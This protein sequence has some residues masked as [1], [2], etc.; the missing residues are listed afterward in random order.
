M[1]S[2]NKNALICLASCM[3]FASA[4]VCHA[5]TSTNDLTGLKSLKEGY[6]KACSKIESDN[7]SARQSQAVTYINELQ[8]VQ[9][10][11]QKAG[12]LEGLTAAKSE[13]ERF[14]GEQTVPETPDSSLPVAI[15]QLQTAYKK[16]LA[17][18]DLDKS[19]KI[20]SAVKQYVDRLTALQKNLTKAGKV[21]EALEVNAEIKSV[22]AD[23]KVTSA[24]FAVAAAESEKQSQDVSKGTQSD[25]TQKG[26]KPKSVSNATDNVAVDSSGAKIYEGK[27]FPSVRGT[28][29]KNVTLIQSELITGAPKVSVAATLNTEN[30]MEKSS[31][32]Y[33]SATVQSKSG[34]MEYTLRVTVK[35][36]VKS[37]VQE[38]PK[39]VV[40]YYVK[41]TVD[42]GNGEPKVFDTRII[43]LPKID[44]TRAIGVEGPAITISSS[45]SKVVSRY[46]GVVQSRASGNEYYGIILSVFDNNG[47]LIAQ[48][49]SN[50]TLKGLGT[51]KLPQPVDSAAPKGAAKNAK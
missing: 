35:S 25:E 48:V 37:F 41:N 18:I 27:S 19:K 9:Q 1:K 31:S 45:T 6:E 49:A 40:Q 36:A 2:I 14:K 17:A 7:S 29:Y 26:E 33:Y 46:R 3:L 12:D 39:L 23:S 10:S 20:V 21:D 50:N 24:D 38:N 4:S 47:A 22:K 30:S 44:G 15:Q 43:S 28:N 11:L 32:A 13:I 51:S 8:K 5:Q 16:G 42:A 34:S